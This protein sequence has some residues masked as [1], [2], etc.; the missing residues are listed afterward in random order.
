MA[1]A[2]E[3]VA[4]IISSSTITILTML[5]LT[6]EGIYVLSMKSKEKFFS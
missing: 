3:E 5:L 4:V 1:I 2:Q 6:V